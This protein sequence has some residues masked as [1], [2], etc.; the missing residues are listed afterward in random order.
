MTTAAA[1]SHHSIGK[2]DTGRRVWAIVG[3][4]SGNLVEWY[5]FYVYSFTPSTSR[6]GS[7]RWGS[8]RPSSG[9]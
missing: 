1:R 2:S 4:S 9:T 8:S 6:C 3:G 7:S 5:D